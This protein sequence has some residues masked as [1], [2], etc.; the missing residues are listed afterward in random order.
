MRIT[1][2]IALLTL[3]LAGGCSSGDETVQPAD[4]PDEVCDMVAIDAVPEWS[5][6]QE[7]SESRAD[8]Q[9][10]N[11]TCEMVGASDAGNV[12]L[13]LSVVSFGGG[14][15]ES[16]MRFAS[17][18]FVTR[19][20]WTTDGRGAGAGSDS[21]GETSREDGMTT[22][23]ALRQVSKAHGVVRVEAT[24]P[25]GDPDEVEDAVGALLDH[26]AEELA[27]SAR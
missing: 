9:V 1:R 6:T 14:D 7:R 27:G 25:A 17:E 13:A 19:C 8:D 15:E 26:A 24:V 5:L 18:D 2:G 20:A 3:L 23:T 21:C 10:S 22:S 12:R 11:A 4:L 16:A